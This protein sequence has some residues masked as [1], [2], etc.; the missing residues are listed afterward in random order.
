M[1]T[2][3]TARGVTA[4]PADWTANIRLEALARCRRQM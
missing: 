1:S 4:D 2:K 3:P